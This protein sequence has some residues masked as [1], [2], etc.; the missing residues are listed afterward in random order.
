VSDEDIMGNA[1]RVRKVLGGGMR[2][3][4]YLAAAGL[5]A[6][7]NHIERLEEDHQRAKEIE[8]VLLDLSYIK[9]VEP[10][11][12]NIVI[13]YLDTKIS[14][15]NFLNHLTDKGIIISAMGEGKW[16]VVTHLDYTE[17]Q[18]QTFIK[19]LQDFKK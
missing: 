10:V 14:G 8:N 4:G 3:V 19:T 17:E 5:Y 2:Q 7:D 9:S 12:T 1:M 11:E 6:L 13:F 18:H 16:R 15:E